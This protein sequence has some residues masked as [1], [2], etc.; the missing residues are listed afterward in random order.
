MPPQHRFDS[1]RIHKR[2]RP[3][4]EAPRFDWLVGRIRTLHC[5]SSYLARSSRCRCGICTRIGLVLPHRSTSQIRVAGARMTP[6]ER[7]HMR[8]HCTQDRRGGDGPDHGRSDRDHVYGA[9][10]R[11]PREGGR[12][13]DR[14]G[15][16]P[17]RDRCCALT[18]ESEAVAGRAHP[19][20]CAPD[21]RPCKYRAVPAHD[22][23]FP[24]VGCADDPPWAPAYDGRLQ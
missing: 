20:M 24:Q 23:R 12:D 5:A 21:R 7:R 22:S 16:P 6:G 9:E 14:P 8:R 18:S 11:Q 19:M 1:R 2:S 4:N 10:A 13:A 17:W 3:G 15:W